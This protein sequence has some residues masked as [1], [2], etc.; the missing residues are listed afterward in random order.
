MMTDVTGLGMRAEVEVDGGHTEEDL[1]WCYVK[2]FDLTQEDPGFGKN[3]VAK[4]VQ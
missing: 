4:S 1:V 3:R 2:G